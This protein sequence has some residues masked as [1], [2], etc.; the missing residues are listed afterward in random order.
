MVTTIPTTVISLFCEYVRS[1]LRITP[2]DKPRPL[3]ALIIFFLALCGIKIVM[4]LSNGGESRNTHHKY[5]SL[6]RKV[7]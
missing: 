6:T 5:G 4:Y 2:S 1:I 3:V 7:F